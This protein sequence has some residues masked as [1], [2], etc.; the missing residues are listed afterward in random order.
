MEE[1]TSM[2]TSMEV[3]GN[4]FTCMEF[5]MVVGGIRFTPWKLV[6]ASMEIHGRFHCLSVDV[7]ASIGSIN[8]CS[9]REYIPWKLP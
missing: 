3:V 9:F 6:E 5:S 8:Y 1:F 7:E 4:R 2:E